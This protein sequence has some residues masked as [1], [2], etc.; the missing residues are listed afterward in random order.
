VLRRAP[1]HLGV[2]PLDITVGD[3]TSRRPRGG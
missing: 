1:S 2:L 3:M